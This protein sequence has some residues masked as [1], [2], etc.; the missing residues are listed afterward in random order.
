M[1]RVNALSLFHGEAIAPPS[2]KMGVGG[3]SP[4]GVGGE[5]GN[6]RRRTVEGQGQ[7]KPEKETERNRVWD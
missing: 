7:G 5:S 4:C 3:L 1:F 6:W 2:E